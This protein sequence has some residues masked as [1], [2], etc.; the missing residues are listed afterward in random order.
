MGMGMGIRIRLKRIVTKACIESVNKSFHKHHQNAAR[1]RF[2][3]C[4]IFGQLRYILWDQ[5]NAEILMDDT[6]EV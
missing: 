3:E 4:R 6:F 2:W 1:V 5:L